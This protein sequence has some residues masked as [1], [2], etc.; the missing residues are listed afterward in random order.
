MLQLRDIHT[1]IKLGYFKHQ[2][3]QKIKKEKKLN[4]ERANLR[5]YLLENGLNLAF[6]ILPITEIK[7]A[8]YLSVCLIILKKEL[9]E[10]ACG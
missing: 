4:S 10:E 9:K 7:N 2:T 5:Q 3:L 8:A 6:E 1:L